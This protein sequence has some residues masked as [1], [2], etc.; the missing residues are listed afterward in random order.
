MD[1]V[2]WNITK[3]C[4]KNCKFCFRET[5][6]SDL[7]L[8]EN[9]KILEGLIKQG[10]KKISWSGGEPT[11]Y[12]DLDK[13]LKIAKEKNIYNKMI[14]N[15][16]NLGNK[17][18]ERFLLYLDE[19]VF[20]VDFVDDLLNQIYG[21]GK[22]YYKNISNIIPQIRVKYPK[23]LIT[24]NTIVMKPN[25]EHMNEIYTQVNQLEISKWKLIQFCYFRGLAKER[26]EEF[27][28]TED[29]FNEILKKYKTTR[30]KFQV[31]GHTAEE[32]EKEHIVITPSG[33]IIQ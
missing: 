23:C 12:E 21:R 10:I 17:N 27:Y 33:K 11:E 2:C 19:I 5:N 3:K 32:M 16:S 31:E 8:N 6:E 1:S 25:L 13:L 9:K 15:A 4:S 30:N 28:I 14:T 29:C 22:S 7:S 24:I 26:K 20:S 18:F